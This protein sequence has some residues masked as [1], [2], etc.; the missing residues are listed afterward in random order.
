[1]ALEG[2]KVLKWHFAKFKVLKWHMT[3]FPLNKSFNLEVAG[4][5]SISGIS[6]QSGEERR[7]TRKE[8]KR[9]GLW[10]GFLSNIIDILI[11]G[12]YFQI[13]SIPFSLLSLSISLR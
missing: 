5:G 7:E 4:S 13:Q 9:K 1:V 12:W 11:S 2:V 8:K 10:S 6:I 3:N